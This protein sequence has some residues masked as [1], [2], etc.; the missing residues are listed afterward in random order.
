MHD[1]DH[2]CIAKRAASGG[3][4]NVVSARLTEHA[5]PTGNEGSHV[6]FRL[7]NTARGGDAFL[8]QWGLFG[9]IDAKT[10][11]GSRRLV[12]SR[13]AEGLVLALGGEERCRQGV[14]GCVGRCELHTR[15]DRLHGDGEGGPR[16]PQR[17]KP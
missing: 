8:Y 2:L 12:R 9:G 6:L 5:V 11:I 17:L 10:A 15:E 1:V 16:R 7:A 4:G 13:R 3:A 14:I